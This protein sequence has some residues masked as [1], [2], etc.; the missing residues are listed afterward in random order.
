MP[1]FFRR[2][3]T[4][5]GGRILNWE[6]SHAPN[7]GDP[8]RGGGLSPRAVGERGPLRIE[9][10]RI[11]IDLGAT[12]LYVT[13]DQIEAMTLADRIGVLAEGELVQLGAPRD[14]YEAPINAYVARRLGSPQ[15]NLLPR[16]VLALADGPA[17][18]TIGVR[19]EDV[20]IGRNGVR[21]QVR[22]VEH[23]GA[24]T[25][26]LLEVAGHELHA[27]LGRIGPPRPRRC[28]HGCDTPGLAALFR[29]RR[30]PGRG[31]A[32]SAPADG[33]GTGLWRL[34]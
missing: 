19:P 1:G 27:L 9:L 7:Q 33:A 10:K 31:S 18:A 26:A 22:T 14:M 28:H 5:R 2:T 20:L 23:L 29:C 32:H 3:A 4:R 8:G 12:I 25:V 16:D 34:S 11:Q 6:T 21:A 13:H 30:Q 24:E 15:I 17:A